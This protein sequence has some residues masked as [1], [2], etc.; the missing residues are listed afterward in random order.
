MT[1]AWDAFL[2]TIAS[3]ILQFSSNILK[4]CGPDWEGRG[5][6]EVDKPRLTIA[7]VR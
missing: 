6:S 4:V 3:F 1:E 2:R 7:V 5:E